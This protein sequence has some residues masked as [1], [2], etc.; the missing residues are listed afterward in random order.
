VSRL[1]YIH[2]VL[3]EFN[4]ILDRLGLP[5]ITLDQIG[6]GD[7]RRWDLSIPGIGLPETGRLEYS[8]EK[9]YGE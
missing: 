5:V 1:N 6:V 7:A 9:R 4:E 8:I 3:D 2:S